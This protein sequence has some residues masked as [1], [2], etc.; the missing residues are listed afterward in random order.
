MKKP[1]LKTY[2]RTFQIFVAI[3]FIIIPILN[4]TDYSY[5]YGNYFSFHLFGI[6]FA[7]P[8]AVLQLTVKNLY[9]TVDN[10][11]GTL[12]PLLLAFALGTVFCSWICAY[13]LLSEWTQQLRRIFMGRGRKG[14]PLD[15]NGFP[16]KMAI[17]TLGFIGFFIFSTTPILN[18][19]SMPAWY[20]RF[21]QYWFGQDILSLCF[22]FILAVLA[23]EFFAG[24]RLWCRYVCPQSILITLTKQFNR[25]RMK[26]VFD[27]EKCIC[28]PGR[29][30][31]ESSC[32]LS[33]KPK[34]LYDSAELECSN[35]GDCVVAC[36]K[37]GKALSFE[38]LQGREFLEMTDFKESIPEL[39]KIA[40]GLVWLS[41]LM[42]VGYYAVPLLQNV[43]LSR[44]QS[45]TENALLSNKK[46]S[47][48]N[49]RAEYYELLKSGTLI[50]VGGDWPVEGFKGWQWE[51]VDENGSFKIIKEASLA[52]TYTIARMNSKIGSGSRFIM[53]QYVDGSMVEGDAGEYS[54]ETYDSLASNHEETATVMDARVIL[55]RYADEVYILD[56]SVLDPG[57]KKIKKVLSEGDLITMEGMLTAVHRWINS[58]VIT[59]SE[60]KP[61]ELP[62]HSYM[63]MRF[64]DG[65]VKAISF[66]TKSTMDRSSEVFEDLWF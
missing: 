60:G 25:K 29:E 27:R 66:V 57:G 50:C 28:K 49:G 13:G 54:I 44:E 32:T 14:I 10:A 24:K 23:L 8:L 15:S 20:T 16:F 34:T 45:M 19:L 12:L 18:Q 43:E 64:R 22:L 58:P 5:V 38:W 17:F 3:S 4:R 61:P 55:N 6:P 2:R 33:L 42:V 41:L 7:D 11:I 48:N 40:I 56:L 36:K 35:C 31:C 26:V 21:F 39:K 65:R 63:E 30:R 53:E 9:L 1:T 62:I 52:G 37:M 51:P 47:W 59:A 46:I